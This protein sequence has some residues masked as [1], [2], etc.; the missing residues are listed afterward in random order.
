MN[1]CFQN[2]TAR[3]LC[4]V[5]LAA[6]IIFLLFPFCL[7]ADETTGDPGDDDKPYIY[8]VEIEF[9]SFGFYYDWGTWNVG[10]FSY[11]TDPTSRSPAADTV[12]GKP[13]WYGF[14]GITNKIKVTN[15][16]LS[17]AEQR[18]K[19]LIEYS[20]VSDEY[21]A[22]PLL[23][24]SV[25]MYCYDSPS[26]DTCLNVF[27]RTAFIPDVCEFY[28]GNSGDSREIYLSFSGEPKTA[29]GQPYMS[30]TAQKIGYI[31]LGVALADK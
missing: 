9:G 26:F 4:A 18:I 23:P 8:A 30:G 6:A 21:N 15:L 3:S 28:M 22:F 20:G 27:D 14:D 1:I 29:D 24:G 13:G 19:I 7:R 16:T 12:S 10:T 17:S 11:E 31:T 5:F 25:K 2:R